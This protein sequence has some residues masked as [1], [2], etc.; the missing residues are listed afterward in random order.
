MKDYQY[1]TAR[2]LVIPFSRFLFRLANN[3]RAVLGLVCLS[4]AAGV[5]GYHVFEGLS[6]LDA[7]LNA[8]MILGGMGPVDTLHTV[9]GKLFAS[10]YAIYSGLFLIAVTGFI[11]APVFHRVLHKFHVRDEEDDKG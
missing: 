6:W 10:V 7:L 8:S 9:G 11:M 3:M 4:L 5:L 1:E 2:D